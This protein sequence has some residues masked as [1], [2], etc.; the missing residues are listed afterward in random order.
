MLEASST[1]KHLDAFLC[2]GT[3]RQPTHAASAFSITVSSE[4]TSATVL[5]IDDTPAN[6]AV[7]VESLESH[8]L[9]VVVAQR[10]QEALQRADHVQPDLILLDVMMPDLDGF[11]ICR[12]LKARPSTRNIPVIFMTSPS[13]SPPAT[14][15]R[16]RKYWSSTHVVEPVMLR[17]ADCRGK[18]GK[19]GSAYAT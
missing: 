15:E 6:L 10:A 1:R 16:A 19:N 17:F 7:I 9:R 2:R 13:R 5:I 12:R 4:N 8:G 11:E 14:P 18:R 3:E